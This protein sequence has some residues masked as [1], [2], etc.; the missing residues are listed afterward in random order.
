MRTLKIAAAAFAAMFVL[1]FAVVF[2]IAYASM[3]NGGH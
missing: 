2:A 3:V 1:S